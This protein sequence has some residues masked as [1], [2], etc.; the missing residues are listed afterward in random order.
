MALGRERRGSRLEAA[1]IVLDIEP[2]RLGTNHGLRVTR[3]RD[4]QNVI[5]KNMIGAILEDHASAMLGAPDGGSFTVGPSLA[6]LQ[7][8]Y[9]WYLQDDWKV[10]ARSR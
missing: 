5:G 8:S 3:R 7:T 1:S 9:N 6:L 4:R 2:D 10:R